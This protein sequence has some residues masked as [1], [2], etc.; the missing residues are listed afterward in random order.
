MRL[1]GLIILVPGR[2]SKSHFIRRRTLFRF[3]LYSVSRYLAFYSASH[4]LQGRALFSVAIY[5][6]KRFIQRR[7][8][9]SVV[10]H[11]ASHFIQRRPLFSVALYSAPQFIQRR[12]LFGVTLYS[13]SALIIIIFHTTINS[14]L[15]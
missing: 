7:A 8:L 10:F 15:C 11:S 6:S 9:F 12:A 3:A 13:A 5:S 1:V 4:C 2:A 14:A